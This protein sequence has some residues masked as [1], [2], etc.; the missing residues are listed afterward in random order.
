VDGRSIQARV[1]EVLDELPESQRRV[2]ELVVHDPESV[3]FGTLATIAADAGSSTATVVRFAERLGFAGFSSLR[4]AVRT[5]VSSK[6]RS[7]VGRVRAPIDGPLLDRALEVEQANVATTLG[8]LDRAQFDRAV[9][10]L[11]DT[12]R[13]VW[14]LPNTQVA[15]VVSHLAD[16]LA[17]CRPKV[18]LL[19][20]SEFRIV[21]TLAALA[22]GDVV[23]SVDTQRHERWLVRVQRMAVGRGAVPV[24][25]TDR[26]PCSLDT[27]G[28]VALT[29]ACETTSPFESQVGL[30]ALGNVL[31]SGV[32]DRR[33]PAV[34]RRVDALEA[35]WVDEGLFDV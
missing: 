30:V 3:A 8:S 15:G 25:I 26:L 35:T 31:V 7:A 32:V 12:D 23:V 10:L 18:T 2:A 14:L 13:R 4:D 22:A 19:E 24:V 9:D 1:V 20:G 21:T 11:A 27:S 34:I 33:R 17:L 29:F 28:G 6:F 16:D 5:E